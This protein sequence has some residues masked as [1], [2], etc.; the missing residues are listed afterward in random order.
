M[1]G[2][3]RRST[4]PSCRG[5]LRFYSRAEAANYAQY[6]YERTGVATRVYECCWCEGWHRTSR[7]VR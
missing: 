2:P 6:R 1:K 5:K 4:N 3:L 7:G